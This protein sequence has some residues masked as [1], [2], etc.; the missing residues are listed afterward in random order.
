MTY[1]QLLAKSARSGVS[2]STLTLHHHSLTVLRTSREILKRRGLDLLDA[3]GL[4]AEAWAAPLWTAA[5]LGAGL[6]DLGK[7]SSAFQA[8][9][10][11]PGTSAR[12]GLRHDVLALVILAR[13]PALAE[14]LFGGQP[15]VIR[16]AVTRAVAGHHLRLD[17]VNTLR[18]EPSGAA[19]LTLHCGHPDVIAMLT[20]IGDELGKTT[21]PPPLSDERIDL[22]RPDQ[23][24]FQLLLAGEKW[25][26]AADRDSR[27]FC[28]AVAAV[29]IASDVGGS[30]IARVP[31]NGDAFET[32]PA[33]AAAV[34]ERCPDASEYTAAAERRLGGAKPRPFQEAV[35]RARGQ[36]VVVTAGCGS[37]KTVAA[38]FWAKERVSTRKLYFC[39]PTTGTATEGYRD[40]AW[41]EF[42][43]DAALIHSRAELDYEE[44]LANGD[45]RSHQL[46]QQLRLDALDRWGAK[47]SVCTADT[48]LGLMQ[49]NRQ[50]LF[51]YPAIVGAGFV[52]DEV[53]LYDD[54]MFG[55]LLRFLEAMPHAPVL[56][57]TATLQPARR[58]ALRA[59]ALLRGG[60]AEEIAGPPELE[61]LPRYRLERADR[62][63][64]LVETE[65]MVRAGRPVLW[66]RNTV[67]QARA[68]AIALQE[69]G[70]R[71][72]V[73]HSRF[74]YGD[75]LVRHRA[76]IDAFAGKGIPL[77]AVATQVC[78]VSLDISAALL[79]TEV[80]PP[81]SLI[82][83]LGRLNRRAVPGGGDPPARAL[84]IDA[85]R[86]APYSESDMEQGE[87]WLAMVSGRPV[88]QRDL[89]NAFEELL[90]DAP[91]P[92][93]QTSMWLDKGWEIRPESV[94]EDGLT[95]S[96][97]MEED[98]PSCMSPLGRPIRREIQRQALP[99]LVRPVLTEIRNWRRLGS[100]LVAPSGRISY[101]PM[102]G[103]E[104]VR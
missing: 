51:L 57:M 78:E 104:W 6:H 15:E 21:P 95:A 19:T 77:V 73:Y 39:Y 63:H 79:V 30:A 46:E 84:V 71:V 54:R 20:S 18:P 32:A 12:Q 17:G 48:V 68:D 3:H 88:S 81:A 99:M 76:V 75:R 80:A 53:H 97:L 44:V 38:W 100:M 28:A 5:E 69:R 60:P 72:E 50:G 93:Q 4:E 86:S 89:A 25:W 49:N 1:G 66:V 41:P 92:L 40:Y 98:L 7:C 82:Q 35:A 94:R 67:A 102:W 14:W 11:A 87:Q 96:F 22:L 24:A 52:F 26:R 23:S 58:E 27:V 37:G 36:T 43:V 16:W 31:G 103:G 33:R 61:R 85:R 64:A 83:R 90:S 9:I 10:R 56:L 47:V 29:V 2:P 13:Y 101:S 8:M 55:L 74:R 70:V 59:C 34:L 45:E 91:A 42:E 62:S 65:E